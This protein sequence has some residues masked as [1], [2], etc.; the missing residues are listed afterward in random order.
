MTKSILRPILPRKPLYN[1]KAFEREMAKGLK[2]LGQT[3]EKTFEG[4]TENWETKVKFDVD[5]QQNGAA[6]TLTVA[7]DNAIYGYVNDGTRAHEIRP[8]RAPLLRFPSGFVSKTRPNSLRSGP[9]RSFGAMVTAKVVHHPGTTPRH[10]TKYVALKHTKDLFTHIQDAVN[11]A[12][13]EG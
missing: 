9:G 4:T 6:L 8:V 13:K 2:D 3:I 1:V 10:F 11:R 5:V 7:T 12:A